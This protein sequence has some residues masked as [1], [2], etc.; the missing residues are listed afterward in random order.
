MARK[1]EVYVLDM[2]EPIK[3]L[4]LARTMVELAGL[5]LRTADNPD[6]D[7]GVEFTGLQQGEKLFEELNIGDDV[8]PTAHPRIMRSSEAYLPWDEL[9]YELGMLERELKRSSGPEGAVKKLM[10]IA[11]RDG[12]IERQIVSRTKADI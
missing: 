1:S 4:R 5:T 12:V 10:E 3:I 6:G 7:I 11:M 8:T 2:G 9:G